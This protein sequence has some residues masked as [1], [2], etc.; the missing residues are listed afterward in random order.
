MKLDPSIVDYFVESTIESTREM[1]QKF[2]NSPIE[3]EEKLMN[4]EAGIKEKLQ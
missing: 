3:L 2:G 4:A 1:N